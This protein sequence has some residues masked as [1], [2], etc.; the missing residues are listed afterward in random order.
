LRKKKKR[1]RRRRRWRRKGHVQPRPNIFGGWTR[2]AAVVFG[3][4]AVNDG[5]YH[6]WNS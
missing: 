4:T 6:E 2:K 1:R 5:M 3:C